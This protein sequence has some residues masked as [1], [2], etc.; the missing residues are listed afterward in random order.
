MSTDESSPGQSAP[1]ARQDRLLQSEVK[2]LQGKVAS[3]EK[4]NYESKQ[5]LAKYI[6]VDTDVVRRARQVGFSTDHLWTCT[7]LCTGTH[8]D[9]L[10]SM[11]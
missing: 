7:M 5:Q 2:E 8:A 1:S 10:Y 3:L 6:E 4:E 9:Q 11:Q